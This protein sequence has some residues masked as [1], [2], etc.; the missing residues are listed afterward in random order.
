MKCATIYKRKDKLYFHSS[1]RT[2]AGVWIATGPFLT[3]E[4]REQPSTKG[5][6]LKEVL[7]AS[8]EE[9]A[10]PTSWGNLFEPI[11]KL[12]NVKSWATFAKSADCCHAELEGN[13]LCFIPQRNLGPKE[14]YEPIR[15]LTLLVSYNASLEELGVTLDSAFATCD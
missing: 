6:F 12:A 11:L 4:D 1:S 13:K 9:I 15:E 5:K 10:H 8:V 7:G 14:G 2:T 3:L